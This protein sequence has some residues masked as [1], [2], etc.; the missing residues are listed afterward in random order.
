MTT[1]MK[2]PQLHELIK[3]AVAGVVSKVDID[4]E[5]ER[6]LAGMAAAPQEKTAS[7]Q[8]SYVPTDYIEKLAGALDYASGVLAKQAEIAE[9]QLKPGQGPNALQVLEAPSGENPVQPGN[10]GSA[11][12]KNTPPMNPPV[13]STTVAKDPAN[14]MDDNYEMMHGEQPVEPISNE[15]ASVKAAHVTALYRKNRSLLGLNKLAADEPKRSGALPDWAYGA[16][17]GVMGAPIAGGL[18]PVAGGILGGALSSRGGQEAAAAGIDPTQGAKR[19]A[20]GQMIGAVPGHLLGAGLG[21]AVGRPGLGAL[22]GGMA[23]AGLGHHLAMQKYK[24]MQDAA[25]AAPEAEAAKAASAN[26]LYAKNLRA[27]GMH[28]KAEDALSPAK[29]SAGPAEATGADAPPAASAAEEG[30]IPSEPSDVNKQKTMISSNDAAIDYQKREAKADP[31]SDMGDVVTEP[32]QSASTDKTLDL[33]FAKT[34]EAGAKIASDLTRTAAAQA[35]L[36]KYAA[37]AESRRRGKEKQSQM[38]SGGGGSAAPGMDPKLTTPAGQ[39]GMDTSTPN[40]M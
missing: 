21:S 12:A 5:A 14:T 20:I 39:T 10:Q 23:G 37:E 28:K 25:A 11:T 34:R 2:R 6:Q 19:S 24:D 7:A 38:S 9:T 35:L 40:R 4:A 16:V 32:A 36:A 31:K 29:I 27:L 8:P 26:W 13:T 1:A 18:G 3:E 30:P 17:P 33:V 15:K 22:G